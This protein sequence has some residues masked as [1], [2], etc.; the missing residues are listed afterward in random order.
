[1]ANDKRAQFEK[2]NKIFLPLILG[3]SI[4]IK[5]GAGTRGKREGEDLCAKKFLSHFHKFS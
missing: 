5:G 3:Q 4:T 1:M 2:K